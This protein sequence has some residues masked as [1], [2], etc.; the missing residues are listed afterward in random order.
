MN[1]VLSFCL[2]C[3]TR[4][5]PAGIASP[6]IEHHGRQA[7]VEKEMPRPAYTGGIERRLKDVHGKL[8]GCL[9]G[10]FLSLTNSSLKT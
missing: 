5:W 6:L 4:K 3:P 10:E 9:N 2:R 1:A 7:A 8:V